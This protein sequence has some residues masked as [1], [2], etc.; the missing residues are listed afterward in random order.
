MD[1]GSVQDV[2]NF[3]FDNTA[4]EVIGLVVIQEGNE[5]DVL[6]NIDFSNLGTDYTSIEVNWGDGEK[7]DLLSHQYDASGS[8]DITLSLYDDAGNKGGDTVT[9][10]VANVAPW[11]FYIDMPN[12]AVVGHEVL[13][14]GFANDVNSDK[15]DLTFSWDFGD[16]NA[17][18]GKEVSNIFTAEGKYNVTLEITDDEDTVIAIE[19]I[20]IYA[21]NPI[22]SQIGVVEKNTK[23]FSFDTELSSLFSCNVVIGFGNFD[24]SKDGDSC[25]LDVWKPT[26]NDRGLHTVIVKASNETSTKY[27]SFEFMIYDWSVDLEKG[28]NLFSI[29][30]EVEDSK[31]DTVLGGI[32]GNVYYEST[33]VYSVFQYDA[34]ED[35]WSRARTTSTKSKYTASSRKLTHIV[36]GYGY[37]INMENAD[38]IYGMQKEF[39]VNTFPTPSVELAPASWNLIGRYGTES[40]MGNRDALKSLEGMW[41]NVLG[42]ENS[43][44]ESK[45]KMKT[46]YGYWVRTKIASDLTKI[47]YLPIE[48]SHM[49][50]KNN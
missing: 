44:W 23:E 18:N 17:A 19:E 32:L 4:P 24:V 13:L 5:K 11:D 50:C 25:S 27:Y 48:K 26:E 31:I 41:H 22:E 28:W 38:V 21:A 43:I 2:I 29:P 45:S 8:F 6:T 35:E 14:E 36:P 42:Y 3:T 10:M 46:G 12:E 34:I 7:N 1:A 37:W 30:T 20:S 47:D 40:W 15:D 9:V 16:G 33:S 49:S 39:S